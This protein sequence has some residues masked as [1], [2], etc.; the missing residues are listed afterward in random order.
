MFVKIHSSNSLGFSH[1][2]NKA[3]SCGALQILKLAFNFS[4]P[5]LSERLLNPL[6]RGHSWHRERATHLPN[7]TLPESDRVG[8][9]TG[10][11]GEALLKA[12]QLYSC[13][14]YLYPPPREPLS[15]QLRCL[16]GDTDSFK[17]LLKPGVR[18]PS[19]SL[20]S[21]PWDLFLELSLD[22]LGGDSYRMHCPGCLVSWPLAWFRQWGDRCSSLEGGWKG[23]ARIF[24]CLSACIKLN[25]SI[26]QCLRLAMVP[27][28]P[29]RPWAWPP[30][31]HLI[32][33]TA[34]SFLLLLISVASLSL[35]W[36]LSAS[37]THIA[38]Y[39][40]QSPS[41][42]VSWYG[43]CFL[44]APT[45]IIT[46]F[47]FLYI[48]IFGWLGS[49]KARKESNFTDG[50]TCTSWGLALLYALYILVLKIELWETY[51][52][53]SPFTKKSLDI[54]KV[55]WLAQRYKAGKWNS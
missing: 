18:S 17:A 45:E 41:S 21:L 14:S 48:C 36:L 49:E 19:R 20:V 32:Y 22:G 53:Y 5:S 39:L 33:L 25:P 52:H 34:P 15:N 10:R 50:L 8:T 38:N 44:V 16:Y 24:L 43:S 2:P 46:F 31:W 6:S 51:Y 13:S 28:P 54:K 11:T 23:K 4:W 30:G 35:V 29:T 9:W 1:P 27:T 42:W 55:W 3:L 47:Q 26:L 12:L 37:I 7:V 40:H